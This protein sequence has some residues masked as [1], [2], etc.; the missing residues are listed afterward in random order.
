MDSQWRFVRHPSATAKQQLRASNKIASRIELVPPVRSYVVVVSGVCAVDLKFPRLRVARTRKM[1]VDDSQLQLYF[2]TVLELTRNAGK[3]V[4]EHHNKGKKVTIKSCDV[5]LVTETDQQVEKLLVTSLLTKFPGHKYIGE[6]AVADGKPCELTDE[7]TW[8]IDPVDGTMNFVHGYPNF[9]ISVA[10]WIKKKP[11]I[12]IIY[13]PILELMFTA[14]TGKGAFLNGNRISTSS[15]KDLEKGLL[16]MEF[17]TSRDPEKMAVVMENTQILLPLLH[18]IRS[19]GSAALNM[20]MV[21]MG[22]ADCYFEFGIHVWDIAAGV[23]LI[24][25]AGGFVSDPAGGELDPL[26]RRVL[27]ASNEEFAKKIIPHLKQHYPERD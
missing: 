10:L 9:C 14:Q 12:G 8:I 18:G 2:D 6:E 1:D 26:S 20:A 13:N 24:Q 4:R 5:D 22:G 23:P 11:S 17:G 15:V 25:E 16:A 21:A 27:V 3:I 7:P 19:S